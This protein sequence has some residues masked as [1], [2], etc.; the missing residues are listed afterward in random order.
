MALTDRGLTFALCAASGVFFVWLLVPIVLGLAFTADDLSSQYLPLRKLYADCLQRHES[1]LWSPNLYGGFYLHGEG[2]A[3]MMHPLHLLL[4]WVL[5]LTTAFGLEIFLSYV[6]LFAGSYFLFRC[7]KLGTQAALLGSFLFTFGGTNLVLMEHMN[8]VS[9]VAHL[10]WILAAIHGVFQ[11]ITARR[12]A[13]WLSAVALLIGS[14][15]LLGH[16][17]SVYFCAIVEVG[18]AVCLMATE[19][20]WRSFIGVVGALA[21][22]LAVGGVQ[23]LPTLAAVR[24]SVRAAP[25]MAFLSE[26]SLQPQELLQWLNPLMWKG[27]RY[28]QLRGFYNYLIYFGGTVTLLLFVWILTRTEL[29]PTKRRLTRFL[30]IIGFAGMFLA[31]G[32]YNLLFPLYARLPVI[33]LFRGPARYTILTDFAVAAGVAIAWDHL[34]ARGGEL[35]PSAFVRRFAVF[36]AVCSVATVAV[37]FVPADTPFAAHVASPMVVIAGASMVLAG[38]LLFL[39]AARAQVWA[40]SALAIFVLLD[41]VCIQGAIL[42]VHGKI[43]DPYPANSLPVDA[44]GPVQ[45]RYGDDLVLLNY[46]LV[47]GYSGL[48]PASPI[49]IRSPIYARIMGAR[50]VLTDRWIVLS[51]PLPLVRLRNRAVVMENR[52]ALMA[53]SSLIAQ[54]ALME[55]R[56]APPGLE[57][58]LK[59]VLHFDFDNAA[60]VESP[61]TLDREAGG[62]LRMIAEQPG[63]MSL[64]ADVTGAMLAT[65]GTRYHAGWRVRL[66]GKLVDNL[67]VDGSLLGFVVP[68]GRHRIECR[69]NPDDFRYGAMTSLAGILAVLLYLAVVFTRRRSGADSLLR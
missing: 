18:Y 7:W 27:A 13:L 21:V 34:H 68:T 25:P 11:A 39:T 43:A 38:A 61:V 67:R 26:M 33:G 35:A 65:V 24:D 62:T 51:D 14:Q 12:R 17:Q 53:D 50:A 31:L 49:P 30:G 16:P 52:E 56:Y 69:F 36:L 23:L 37:I 41:V 5:P 8:A 47:D 19:R 45:S 29:E 22:G 4:Y 44:P 46:R 60:L 59:Q 40:C 48:E 55:H 63:R 66:D 28:D 58:D 1:F 54:S 3:G 20:R 42:L 64:V 10:P 9:V 2:Q 6:F 15:V 57:R 32:K